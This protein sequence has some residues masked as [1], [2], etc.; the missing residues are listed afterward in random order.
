MK[1]IEIVINKYNIEVENNYEDIIINFKKI[2]PKII[3]YFEEL[4][5]L[6]ININ[7][8]NIFNKYKTIEKYQNIKFNI[9]N[10]LI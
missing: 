9:L 6:I 10:N 4:N 3:S 2:Y 1:I 5:F 8:N 7:D